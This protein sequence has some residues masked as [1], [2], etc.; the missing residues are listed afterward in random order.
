ML[1]AAATGPDLNLHLLGDF[2]GFVIVTTAAA[3]AV[4]TNTCKSAGSTPQEPGMT[5]EG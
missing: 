5:A 2:S 3:C 1:H 4:R